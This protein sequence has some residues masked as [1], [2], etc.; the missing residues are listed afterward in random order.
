MSILVELQRPYLG[1]NSVSCYFVWDVIMMLLFPP[2]SIQFCLQQG[3]KALQPLWVSGNAACGKWL[4]KGWFV[5]APADKA[6]PSHWALLWEAAHR[7]TV[8]HCH[9]W[10]HFCTSVCTWAYGRKGRNLAFQMKIQVVT[11]FNIELAR[12]YFIA[13]MRLEET[14][15]TESSHWPNTARSTIISWPC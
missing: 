15:N 4:R 6:Q 9:Q 3:F 7:C 11:Y 8:C 10:V 2:Y 13:S 14:C 5:V 1:W 12:G